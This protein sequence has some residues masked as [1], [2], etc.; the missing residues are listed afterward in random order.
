MRTETGADRPLQSGRARRYAIPK[1]CS[2]K[3]TTTKKS[4]RFNSGETGS[5]NSGSRLPLLMFSLHSGLGLMG[6]ASPE[7]WFH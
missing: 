6:S 1:M 7:Q 2:R 5:R 3:T 4:Q